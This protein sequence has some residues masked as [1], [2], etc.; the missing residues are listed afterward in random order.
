MK[1]KNCLILS[2]TSMMLLTACDLFPFYSI[3]SSSDGTSNSQTSSGD[4]FYTPDSY[5]VTLA[6]V[7]YE[8]GYVNL[9]AIGEQ[10][11][12]V[13]P[14]NFTDYDCSDIARGCDTTRSDI[15]KTFFGEASDTGW[16]SVASFYDQSSYGNLTLSGTVTPWFNLDKST[17]QLQNLSGYNDPTYYVLRNAVSWYKTYSGSSLTEYDQNS[18]GYIDAVWL[19]YATDYSTDAETIYW[20]YTYWDYEQ[21][22]SLT[23]PVAN[24]YAWA[25]YN[26]M[27]EG[28]YGGLLTP[29][30]DAHTYIHETG[31]VLGLDDYYTYD[32]GDWGAAGGVD[33]MDYNIA[34][35]NP[36][37]KMALDWTKPY[38]VDGSADEVSLTLS[39]FESSG[40]CIL[41]KNDWNG[42]PLDEYLLVEFYTPTGL[43]EADSELGGYP[44]NGARA[45]SYPGIKIYHI[46]SRMG[47]IGYPSYEFM[48]FTDTIQ[49]GNDYYTDI[50]VSN[51]ASYCYADDSFKLVHLIEASGE[52]TLIEGYMAGDSAL[53]L[54]GDTFN[55]TSTMFRNFF[56]NSGKYNDNSAIGF[57]LH[58][59]S[60]SSS[61][62]TVTISKV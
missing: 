41:I 54:Q 45:F 11:I 34:D 38:V 56:V 1:L 23:S 19:V 16:E 47:K 49:I 44:G 36:Y 4:G 32:D 55:P 48:S 3:P 57:S 29:K 25:S 7:R 42:S 46:D 27:W 10:K 28:G 31:H 21:E 26:F 58:V 37:S 43:N 12:L 15:E 50:A 9:D 17:S 5:S 40:D 53:F 20:A 13:I 2:V 52:N 24:V 14:V 39:P 33:M 51:T 60:V 59:D 30:V 62:A 18:D 8:T 61:Q 6:D 22:A 35:H